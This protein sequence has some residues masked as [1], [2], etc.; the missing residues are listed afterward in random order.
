M[1]R[2][3]PYARNYSTLDASPVS[4]SAEPNLDATSL[5]SMLR[6]DENVFTKIKA[7][8]NVISRP[9]AWTLTTAGE[10][11]VCECLMGDFKTLSQSSKKK[12]VGTSLT[13]RG[14][15]AL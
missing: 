15:S 1:T 8:G 7:F 10:F 11:F 6:N 5:Y 12:T 14:T 9:I 4:K 2:A 3:M 13:R